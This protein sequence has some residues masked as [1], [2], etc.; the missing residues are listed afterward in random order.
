MNQ[1]IPSQDW[2]IVPLETIVSIHDKNRIPL[3]EK[4]RLQM[5]GEYPYCGA[6]GI[7]DHIDDYIFDGEYILLAEDGGYWGSFDNSAYIMKGRFW[8]NNHAHVLQ[9]EQGISDNH[10]LMYQL[11][12]LNIIP[13]IS[14]TTRGK[15]NQG[16]MKR[17]PLV[18]PPL[19]E[20]RTIAHILQ[21]IQQA[22]FTRQS[23]IELERERKAALMN[24][25]FT[26]GTEGEP[27][28]QTEIGEIPE[29]WETKLLGEVVTITKKPRDLR[30]TD[31]SGIPFVPMEL[32]PI[33]KLSSEE[34]ILKTND[35]LTSGTYFQSG[36]ILLSKITP[37]F[38]NGKQ[39]I[40]Q[41]LPDGFGI[42]TTEIIPIHEIEGVTDKTF[43]FY[44]F[45]LPKVRTLLTGKMQGST[46]RQ[47][48][49]LDSLVNLIVPVPLLSE[50]Q[51]IGEIFYKIDNKI[52]A[53]EKEVEHIDELF[54]TMLEELMTGKRSA[55]PL[56]DK[57]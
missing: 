54:H 7:V 30:Y 18:I 40:I 19:P 13:F 22:K 41:E 6:N 16:M 20:Q 25:L 36:D 49:N 29:S 17:V 34:Y 23:E 2:K 24:H 44:Y 47:R 27:R 3:N 14:G 52:A 15:L 33:G 4:Q 57:L 56:I 35:E 55:I 39:C 43:L 51:A 26:R 8:V 32:I 37:S 11:N 12:Y 45:L 10:F 28:K 21:T 48:L 9:A 50:Q 5:R 1:T 53:L 42:A 46:G 38:E 31:Y